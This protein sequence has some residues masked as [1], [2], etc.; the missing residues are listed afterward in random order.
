MY[1]LVC[2]YFQGPYV[3]FSARSVLFERD[4]A[5]DDLRIEDGRCGEGSGRA[6]TY[7]HV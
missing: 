4:V 5:L 3:V 6:H 1:V 7:I 2:L